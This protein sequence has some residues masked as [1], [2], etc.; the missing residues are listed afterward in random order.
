MGFHGFVQSFGQKIVHTLKQTGQTELFLKIVEQITRS[1]L[2][3]ARPP[4]RKLKTVLAAH[5]CCSAFDR[6]LKTAIGAKRKL[7]AGIA[8]DFLHA[9]KQTVF[10]LFAVFGREGLAVSPQLHQNFLF[11]FFR[12]RAGVGVSAA[13][14]FRIQSFLFGKPCFRGSKI[15]EAIPHPVLAALM[16]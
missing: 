5:T 6:D 3:F 8:G 14:V 1:E 16:L 13:Y 7:C 9:F 15:L 4:K 11:P 2:P 12:E 10:Y